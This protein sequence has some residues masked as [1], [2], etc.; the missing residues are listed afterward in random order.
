MF[1]I[2]RQDVVEL[3]ETEI[4]RLFKASMDPL[5]NIS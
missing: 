1:K 4:L 2:R 5:M 3:R